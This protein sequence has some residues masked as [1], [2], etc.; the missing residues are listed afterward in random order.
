LIPSTN[1]IEQRYL[2]IHQ[3]SVYLGLSEKAIYKWLMLGRIPGHKLGRVWRFDK[4]ELDQFVHEAGT[5]FEPFCYNPAS[6][7]NAVGFSRKG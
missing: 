4:A 2:N 6:S 7:R 3:T 5:S 1:P